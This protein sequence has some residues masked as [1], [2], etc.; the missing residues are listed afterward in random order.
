MQTNVL[1]L[2]FDLW[3]RVSCSSMLFSV[4]PFQY[5]HDVARQVSTAFSATVA[6]LAWP[7]VLQWRSKRGFASTC[8]VVCH[9]SWLSPLGWRVNWCHHSGPARHR[10]AQT[11]WSKS[12]RAA[13]HATLPRSATGPSWLDAFLFVHS[14]SKAN[15]QLKFGPNLFFVLTSTSGS[16]IFLGNW[17]PAPI[18]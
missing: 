16:S 15:V 17:F 7:R 6:Q 9:R 5:R 4:F 8:C 3:R 11:S 10:K 12:G 2:E 14:K 1:M 18:V 13:I